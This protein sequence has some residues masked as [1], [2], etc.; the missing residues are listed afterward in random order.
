MKKPKV[1]IVDIETAPIKAFVWDL[2]DQNV[3]LNQIHTDWHILSWAAKWLGD[4]PSKTMYADQSNEKN[5]ENDF[6]ALKKIHAL[7]DEADVIITQNGRRFDQK[8][9]Y[10]RFILN[11]MKPP[12]PFKHIDTLVIAKKNFAFTSNKLEYMSSKLCTKYKKLIGDR[13]YQG[14]TLWSECLKGNK[15]AYKEMKKYNIYDVLALE[16][17]YGK[18]QP[19]DNTINFNLY[20]DSEEVSCNCGSTHF[21]KR[22]YAMTTTGKFHRYQCKECGKWHR[23]KENLLSKDKRKKLL[24]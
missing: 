9:L 18:L 22:G 19:Y 20:H 6:K 14:F 11:G 8:K 10:A 16:E 12:S 4:P 17:L 2:W 7:L 5:V 21:E 24:V 3:A 1:L 15:A 23:G 13:K